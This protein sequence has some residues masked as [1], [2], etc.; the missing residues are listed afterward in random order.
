MRGAPKFQYLL[1]ALAGSV[2]I[3]VPFLWGRWL[4]PRLHPAADL[5]LGTADYSAAGSSEGGCPPGARPGPAGVTVDATAR[6]FRF[7]VKTPAN[8]D[9]G[10]LHPLIVVYA[11]AGFSAPLSEQLVGLTH[12]A[13]ASGFVIV[14]AD[15]QP[16]TIPNILEL[17]T[18]PQRVA[19]KWCIDRQR[20]YFTGH[21]DGGTVATALA[22][23]EPTRAVPAGIAPSAAGFRRQ[24]LAAYP[25]PPPLPVMVM[26]NRDDRLFPGYGRE[27]ARWWAECNRCDPGTEPPPGTTTVVYQACSAPTVYFERR[28]RHQDWPNLNQ[29]VIDFFRRATLRRAAGRP[30]ESR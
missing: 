28:G 5:R 2:L 9:P 27:A 13:T 30:L 22:V 8:Y 24:D 12:L 6:G 7:V 11:P 29:E 18:I 21:S 3:L 19:E 20:I 23:L 15:S 26:H 1:A 17:G 25:C 14:Y 16:L 10:R 4:G